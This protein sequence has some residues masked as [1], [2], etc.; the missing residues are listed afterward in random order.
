MRTKITLRGKGLIPYNYNLALAGA[1]YGPIKRVNTDLAYDI[2]SSTDYKFFTFSWLQIPHGKTS[3]N[4]IFVDGHAHFFVSSP[5]TKI[6][7]AFVEGLLENPVVKIGKTIL[8]VETVEVLPAPQF[9]GKAVFS[10]LSPIIVRTAEDNNGNL[11]TIDLYP[12]DPK[13]YEN[14]RSNLIKKYKNLYN[15]EK[16]NIGFSRPSFT[17]PVRIRIRDT[18][19][20][21]SHMTFE[22]AGDTEL[23]QLGYEAGFGGKNSMGFGMVRVNEEHQKRY[24]HTNFSYPSKTDNKEVNGNG[25]FLK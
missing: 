22:A 14:L 3:K 19:H 4:G 16:S 25:S 9:N 15:E 2:H 12:T 10:T 5:V 7:T 18:F 21:A 23:L 20:R 17:K 1:I 6:V 11:R 8:H 13:F 24:K